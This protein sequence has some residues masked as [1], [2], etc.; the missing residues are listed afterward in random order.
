[1]WL[2]KKWVSIAPVRHTPS[3]MYIVILCLLVLNVHYI[4]ITWT[5]SR[6]HCAPCCFCFTS[7]SGK[8]AGNKNRKKGNGKVTS[9]GL[10]VFFPITGFFLLGCQIGIPIVTVSF[11]SLLHTG[12]DHK[13]RTGLS[14]AL[15]LVLRR[16]KST[17]GR[18]SRTWRQ[19][20]A[21][22]AARCFT[23]SPIRDSSVQVVRKLSKKKTIKR[24]RWNV[25][26]RI[27]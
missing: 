14:R 2:W 19:P 4:I 21:T 15:F 13:W 10:D 11:R 16:A 27:Y 6:A 24:V 25:T 20:S 22:T 8:K 3:T 9:E 1:M 17:N 12:S 18:C 23:V 5:R 7:A 26:R